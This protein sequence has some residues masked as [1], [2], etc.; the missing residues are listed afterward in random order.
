MDS[1]GWALIH[2]LWQGALIALAL[3]VGQRMLFR[4]A[5]RA[6]YGAACAALLLMAL[7]IPVTIVWMQGGEEAAALP[8]IKG[9]VLD[10][11]PPE[12]SGAGWQ[13]WVV[14][15]WALGATMLLLRTAMGWWLARTKSR[16]GIHWD[17]PLSRLM[18]RMNLTGSIDLMVSRFADAPQVFGWLKPVILVPTAAIANLTPGELEAVLAHELAHIIRRDYLVNLIQTVVESLLFYHPAVW[19]VSRSIRQEREHCCDDIAVKVCGDRRRYS[20]AL[21]KLEETR[22]AFAM[23]ATAGGMKM[24]ITRLLG[25]PV[26]GSTWGPGVAATGAIL[27]LG[28]L[29]WA[30]QP[31]VPAPPA[32]P[33]APAV[34]GGAPAHPAAPKLAMASAPAVAAVPAAPLTPAVPVELKTIDGVVDGVA[35]GVVAGV[36]GGV[37]NGIPQPPESPSPAASPQPAAVP[38]V[39]PAPPP[40]PPVKALTDE[41]R[42]KLA[43]IRSRIAEQRAQRQAEVK[44]RMV[45]QRV[46]RQA[47]MNERIVAQQAQR[48]A[49]LAGR[50]LDQQTIAADAQVALELALKDLQLN[51]QQIEVNIREAIE[52]AKLQLADVNVQKEAHASM[53][54]ALAELKLREPEIRKNIEVA[55][56]RLDSEL[57]DLDGK[58]RLESSERKRRIDYADQKWSKGDVKGS[59]TA[60]GRHYLRYGPPDEMETHSGKGENW[61]YKNWRGTGGKMIFEFDADGQLKR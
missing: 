49:R 38:D 6:R 20:R 12:P 18:E 17:Y 39:P 58:L 29:L 24:R 40:P 7:C 3:A 9:L 1:L 57:K 47:E 36:S 30:S 26:E 21:L 32:P 5:P 4:S 42:A 35:G 59:T 37:V 41:E 28:G 43:E 22:P 2:F 19:W 11:G 31:P 15:L 61:L 44:A 55:M 33:E 27:L 53:E 46:Q 48:Q 54:K 8:G 34:A 56:S 14:G 52:K 10:G 23:A 45:E 51:K 50:Q 16:N 60:K 25:Y 13:L